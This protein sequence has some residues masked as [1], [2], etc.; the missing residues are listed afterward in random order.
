[1]T[2]GLPL[3]LQDRVATA[4]QWARSTLAGRPRS[5]EFDA[6]SWRGLGHSG[7]FRMALP[8]SAGGE[9]LGALA[10]TA[11]L[12]ALGRGG[13]DRGLLMA[14]G[15]HLF[16]CMLPLAAHATAGQAERWLSALRDGEVIGA[17]AV[18]ERSGGS[19][20]D[21]MATTATATPDGVMLRGRKSLVCNASHAGL[22]LVLARQFPDRGAMGLTTFLVPRDARRCCR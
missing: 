1:M 3:D 21:Q 15:A 20:F 6:E 8:V 4:D 10:V 5:A 22:F 2:F 13:A 9:G 16:G 17:L 14:A 11:V 7:L 19:G 12:E 18:T